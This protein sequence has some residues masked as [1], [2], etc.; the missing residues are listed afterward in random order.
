MVMAIS[1]REVPVLIFGGLAVLA[2][3]IYVIA[4]RRNEART[5]ALEEVAQQLGFLFAGG[6]QSQALQVGT[7]LFQRGGGRRFRNIMNGQYANYQ[8]SLFDYSYT[9][10]TGKG[11]S[12]LTQTVAAYTQK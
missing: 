7:A 6:D 12:T 5:R 3:V 1:P 9:I 4:K 8:T 2:A 11:S 10:N